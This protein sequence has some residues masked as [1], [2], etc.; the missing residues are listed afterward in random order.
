MTTDIRSCSPIALELL[1]SEPFQTGVLNLSYG[2]AA[3]GG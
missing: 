1:R 2:P 3:P